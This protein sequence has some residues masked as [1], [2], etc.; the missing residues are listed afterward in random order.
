MAI[1]KP[2]IISP[3]NSANEINV[4]SNGFAEEFRVARFAQFG[5]PIFLLVLLVILIIGDPG[6]IDREIRWV[7]VVT[8]VMIAF[9]TI[10]S[11]VSAMRLVKGLLEGSAFSS[12]GQLL[13]I[14]SVVWLTSVIAFALWYWHIDAG[15][16]A[17]RAAGREQYPDSFRFPEQVHAPGEDRSW[18]PQ[19]IDYFAL[20]FNTSTAFSPADVSPI[21]H[22]AKL[23]MILEAAI[24]LTLVALV[25]ARAVNVL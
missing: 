6:R 8:G 5:Y 12:P 23:M 17:A 7:R 4:N 13:A 11:A 19:F 10:M 2:K 15:G 20:S 9:I 16:P 14:G 22:W 24:S 25:V 21:R 3:P 1:A 18:Y